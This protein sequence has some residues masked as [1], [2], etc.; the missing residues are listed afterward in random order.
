M[1]LCPWP[2]CQDQED[3]LQESVT[4]PVIKVEVRGSHALGLFSKGLEIRAHRICRETSSFSLEVND[5]AD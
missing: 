2:T 3:S 5:G 4:L 1:R